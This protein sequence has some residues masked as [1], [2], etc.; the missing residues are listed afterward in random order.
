VAHL[1]TQAVVALELPRLFLGLLLL[2]VVA[3]VEVVVMEP[4]S[5]LAVLVVEVEVVA[6]QQTQEMP[7]QEP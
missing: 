5:V 3:A 7:Q 4:L 6:P 1:L 2:M